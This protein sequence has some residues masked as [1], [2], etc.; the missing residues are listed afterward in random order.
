MRVIFIFFRLFT[1]YYIYKGWHIRLSAGDFGAA[2][3]TSTPFHGHERS[4]GVPP[5]R[6]MY[7][8]ARRRASSRHPQRP[9]TVTCRCPLS[10]R[11]ICHEGS[12]LLLRAHVSYGTGARNLRH[13]PPTPVRRGVTVSATAPSWVSCPVG[14]KLTA[15]MVLKLHFNMVVTRLKQPC[16]NFA[17]NSKTLMTKQFLIF[18]LCTAVCGM[19]ATA[20]AVA[21][22]N[23]KRSMKIGGTL[24]SKYEYQTSE[25]RAVSRCARHV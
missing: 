24:R 11:N 5:V 14:T 9:Q 17:Q 16:R 8:Q 3:T 19:A 13:E 23:Q 7:R 1:P 18:T 25:G 4:T 10:A 2:Q 6:A 20:E 22:D 15:A 21:Q 12:C